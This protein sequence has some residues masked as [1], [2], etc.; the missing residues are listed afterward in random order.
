MPAA[1]GARQTV[2]YD[3]ITFTMPLYDISSD[4]DTMSHLLSSI[5]TPTYR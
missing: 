1:S 5:A 2:I 4:A 3:I